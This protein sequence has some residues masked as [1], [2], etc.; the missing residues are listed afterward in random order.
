MKKFRLKKSYVILM[1][2]G[3]FATLEA[4]DIKYN[5]W[6]E[7][8]SKIGFNNQPIDVNL[9]RYPTDTFVNVIGSF[10]FLGNISSCYYPKSQAVLW[11]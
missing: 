9:G 10:G 3:S 7:S 11:I 5:G 6:L 2:F 1:I 4:F 8:F